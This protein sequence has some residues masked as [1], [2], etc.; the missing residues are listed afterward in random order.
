MHAGT[1]KLQLHGLWFVIESTPSSILDG[2]SCKPKLTAL[3]S[4]L[5]TENLIYTYGFRLPSCFPL[6][7]SDHSCILLY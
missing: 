4:H 7:V 2:E 5:T 6:A 1:L 3:K